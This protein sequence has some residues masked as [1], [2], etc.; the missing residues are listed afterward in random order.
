MTSSCLNQNLNFRIGTT[1]LGS[2]LRQSTLFT[3]MVI[4]SLLEER[5]IAI[6]RSVD[7]QIA[8]RNNLLHVGANALKI[9]PVERIPEFIE[10]DAQNAD[11]DLILSEGIEHL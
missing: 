9:I 2:A 3:S 4:R 5:I 10:L 11:V 8:S 6:A 1:K 7:H